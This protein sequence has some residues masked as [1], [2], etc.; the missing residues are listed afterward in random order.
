MAGP[1]APVHPDIDYVVTKVNSYWGDK[2]DDDN[3]DEGYPDDP[4]PSRRDAAAQPPKVRPSPRPPPASLSVL[5]PWCQRVLLS[6]FVRAAAL[7]RLHRLAPP[8]VGRP[9]L[10]DGRRR[11]IAKYAPAPPSLRYSLSIF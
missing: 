4:W 8:Q 6:L 3:D 11:N 5:C 2:Y 1:S 10:R 7:D 9:R